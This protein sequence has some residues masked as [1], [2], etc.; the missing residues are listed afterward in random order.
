MTR[1]FRHSGEMD[2]TCDN[3]RR[4]VEELTNQELVFYA[5]SLQYRPTKYA[6][7]E[8][9]RAVTMKRAI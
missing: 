6:E 3:S 8:V 9:L 7:I 2:A 5:I 4:L 1:S